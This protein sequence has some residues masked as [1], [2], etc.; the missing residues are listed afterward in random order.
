MVKKTVVE[1][2]V[3]QGDA[4]LIRAA[5][6]EYGIAEKKCFAA[7]AGFFGVMDK[8]AQGVA[9]KNLLE[10]VRTVDGVVLPKL[11]CSATVMLEYHKIATSKSRYMTSL[12]KKAANKGQSTWHGNLREKLGGQIKFL[13]AMKPE[14]IGAIK[15]DRLIA[16]LQAAHDLLPK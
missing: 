16:T 13:K 3:V 15:V 7:W 1:V 9:Y 12:R 6:K 8:T 5:V 2:V 4:T 10:A 14:K 11:K